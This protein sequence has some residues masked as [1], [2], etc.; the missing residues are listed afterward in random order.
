MK[1]TRKLILALVL[2]MSILMT[3][4]VAV[5]PASAANTKTI[6]F[7]PDHWNTA[8]AWFFAHSWN[9]SD[10]ADVKMTDA[11]GDGIYQCEIPS[12]HSMIIFVRKNPSDTNVDWANVWNQTADITIPTDGKNLFT[13][14]AG[15]WSG[16]G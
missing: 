11:D 15:A 1:Q 5:I 13:V 16:A 4:A 6:F 12:G 10:V 3:L 9:G 14:K 2:V 8:N 7:K